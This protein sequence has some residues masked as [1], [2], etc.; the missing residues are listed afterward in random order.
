[1]SYPYA[2][3]YN[4]EGYWVIY[5]N[6][7]GCNPFLYYFNPFSYMDQPTMLT[8]LLLLFACDKP[9]SGK[10]QVIVEQKHAVPKSDDHQTKSFFCCTD[11]KVK[12]LVD[13]HL[14]FTRLLAADKGAQALPKAKEFLDLA[15]MHPD[16]K[17][18]ATDLVHLWTDAKGIQANM[19]DINKKLINIVQK[20]KADKG[21]KIIVA[22]CPMAPGRWLQTE[23]T[24]SNP[25]YGSQMLT[26][27]V[28]E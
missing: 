22:Y 19:E 9:Q 10:N 28:F 23:S 11:P 1:M 5:K 13:A 17:A 27:G 20:S 4:I 7:I 2:M 3:K 14:S 12:A 8:T 18:E 24:I 26:C 15:L 21:E 6:E 16:L 25:Y